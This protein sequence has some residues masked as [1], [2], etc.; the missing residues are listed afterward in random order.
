MKTPS[1]ELARKND[2]GALLSTEE[3]H[4]LREDREGLAI[5]AH[6]SWTDQ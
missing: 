2:D 3:R 6:F 5:S 1:K 4:E